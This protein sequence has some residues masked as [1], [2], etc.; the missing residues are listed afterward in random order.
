MHFKISVPTRNEEFELADGSWYVSNIK[1]SRIFWVYLK[2]WSKNW[3]F[4]NNDICKC[5]YIK[6]NHV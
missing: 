5:M 2:D 6:C 3:S 1:Y 4:F